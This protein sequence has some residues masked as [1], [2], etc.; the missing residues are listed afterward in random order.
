MLGVWWDGAPRV[1]AALEEQGLGG[2]LVCSYAEE[3]VRQ[4]G[5]NVVFTWLGPKHGL[6]ETTFTMLVD[7]ARQ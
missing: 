5:T 7:I 2:Y 1:E 3:K 6:E 4:K